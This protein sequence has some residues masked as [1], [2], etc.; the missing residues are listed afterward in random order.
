VS[1]PDHFSNYPSYV[2][3]ANAGVSFPLY[4]LFDSDYI[5][6]PANFAGNNVYDNNNLDSRWPL[7]KRTAM[8]VSE[9]RDGFAPPEALFTWDG[10]DGLENGEYVLYI[11]TFLPQM[12]ERIEEAARASA[13]VRD[14]PAQGIEAKNTTSFINNNTPVN[15]VLS[16]GSVVPVNAVTNNLLIKDPT[17]PRKDP[18]GRLYDPVYAI[19]VITDPTEARGIAPQLATVADPS[20]KPAGLI[21][22]D[23]WNPTVQYRAGADGYIPYGN[24]TSG[25]WQPQIVR[26]TDNFLAIRVRNVGLPGDVGVLTHVVLSPRKRTAGRVN[27]NTVQQRVSVQGANHDYFSTLLGL[28]GVVNVAQTVYPTNVAGT[29][30]ALGAPIPADDPVGLMRYSGPLPV[31]GSWTAPDGAAGFYAGGP[32]P[33]TRNRFTGDVLNPDSDLLVPNTGL[34]SM[35][36]HQLGA[37]RL[38]AMIAGGRTEHADGRYYES[39]GDLTKDSNAFDYNYTLSRM[40]VPDL[41]GTGTDGVEDWAVYPL[42]NDAVPARRFDEIQARLRAMGNLITVRSDVFEIIMTVEAGYGID[43]NK[44]GFINYRDRNEFVTTAATK[45]TATYERRAPSDQSDSGE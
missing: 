36:A 7:E 8:F 19:D 23:D 6:D 14:L 41:T 13:Q 21:H 33:P 17:N 12:R 44:D 2:N 29:T 9:K 32:T 34:P 24:N 45:A 37:F 38:S 18:N 27:I 1:N 22:P 30:G 42:S 4:Y 10:A 35:A 31:D 28:P 43:Q 15:Y 3:G 39:V 25:G 5:T 16:D 40:D 20:A 26:V 11:G